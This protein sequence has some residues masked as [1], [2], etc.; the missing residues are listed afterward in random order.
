MSSVRAPTPFS[1]QVNCKNAPL[2]PLTG[3][4]VRAARR[5]WGKLPDVSAPCSTL[6][7]SWTM[8]LGYLCGVRPI[9]RRMS[10]GPWKKG[11]RPLCVLAADGCS[12]A[13]TQPAGAAEDGSLRAFTV[14][15]RVFATVAELICV[16]ADAAG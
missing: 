11:P 16:P 10:L 5:Y 1:D 4:P 15:K 12:A 2:V 8:S 7:A 6:L 3:T 9:S 14:L 13:G